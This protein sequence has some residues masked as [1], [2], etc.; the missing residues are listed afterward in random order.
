[1]EIDAVSQAE[2]IYAYKTAEGGWR[3]ADS[4]VS[5]DSVVIAFLDGSSADEIA[6]DFPALS[7]EQVDGAIKFYLQH[8][9]EIDEYLTEQNQRWQE[10]AAES[11]SLHGPLL[12]R[13]R[14]SRKQDAAE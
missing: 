1:L 14:D 3:V 12:S 2:T 8:K 11:E 5:L 10:F 9:Q 4:R 13:L 6:G 7:I